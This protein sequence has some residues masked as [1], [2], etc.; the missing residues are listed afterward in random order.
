MD[1]Q[2]KQLGTYHL[3]SRI[4]RGGM[5]EVWLANQTTL[6]REVAVKVI[7][8]AKA[9]GDDYDQDLAKRFERE[10]YSAARLDHPG[11][12]SVIDYGQAD[13]YLYLIMP[14]VR[15]G[16]L[17]DL[18]K[19]RQLSFSR[20]VDIFG[21]LLDALKYAHQHQIVH[22]D[23]KPANIL[24]REDGRPVIADFG[25]AKIL[26]ENV[27]LTQTG[28]A[29]GSPEYMAPEQFMGKAEPRSDLYSLGVILYQMLT[30]Q[31]IFSGS[32]AVEIAMR[33]INEPVP[34]PNPQIPPP[35]NDFLFKALQKQP[36]QRY[37]DATEMAAAFNQAVRA[38]TGGFPVTN[39]APSFDSTVTIGSFPTPPIGSGSFPVG[40]PS[41]VS[42]PGMSQ[43]PS[44]YPPFGQTPPNSYSGIPQP[45]PPNSYPG[46]PP[47]PYPSSYTPNSFSGQ[48]ISQPGFPV[49][50]QPQSNATKSRSPL[51]FI[52]GA[53]VIVLIVVSGIVAIALGGDKSSQAT[54][55]AAATTV[56]TNSS[57]ASLT[58][59][60]SPQSGTNVTGKAVITDDGN[61][62]ITVVL[63]GANMISGLHLAHIHSGTCQQQ[64]PIVYPLES[65]TANADG[66]G[67]STTIIKAKYSDVINGNFYINIHGITGT[68]GAVASCGQITS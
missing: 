34:L 66:S 48:N 24:I 61:G 2:D 23:L 38:I 3:M 19:K 45:P 28:M 53:V 63:S 47:S 62:Q 17:Y 50:A 26:N 33:H 8:D 52:I 16:S 7:N 59:L 1:L 27:G 4:G 22:R 58:I 32:T 40:T 68:P 25:I 65:L 5:A 31:L 39:P 54:P 35:L 15:G 51:P 41:Q 11:I 64:G 18:I 6:N 20:T 43:P 30:G 37:F 29:V 56:T 10:A 46:P 57:A 14:Y 44:P 60:L 9:N 42:Y 67:S 21:Q 55:T 49:N 36:E 12:L 13:G